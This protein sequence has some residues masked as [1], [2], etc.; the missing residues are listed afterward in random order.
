MICGTQT[1]EPGD[2]GTH[3][4]EDADGGLHEPVTPAAALQTPVALC[5]AHEEPEVPIGSQQM[6]RLPAVRDIVAPVSA[7][8]MFELPDE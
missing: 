5:R 2:T 7:R 4:P 3:V 6:W 8:V 1:S